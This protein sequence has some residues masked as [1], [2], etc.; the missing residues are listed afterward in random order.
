MIT[1]T[2]GGVIAGKIFPDYRKIAAF[3]TGAYAISQSDLTTGCIAAG[4][5][6]SPLILETV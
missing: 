2:A 3:T 4:L 5:F 6:F 1:A